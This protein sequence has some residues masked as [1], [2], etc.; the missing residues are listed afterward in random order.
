MALQD[1]APADD[2]YAQFIQRAVAERQVWGLRSR[3]GWA[4]CDSVDHAS[5]TVVPFWSNR[6][7]AQRATIDDWAEYVATSIPLSEFIDTW[8]V[9]MAKKGILAGP[10]WDAMNCGFEVEA[11]E[12]A[13]QLRH[14]TVLV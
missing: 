6:V 7:E 14:A 13:A 11:D 2:S 10:D 9:A 4:V 3:E 1:H 8:L 5:R 12:L